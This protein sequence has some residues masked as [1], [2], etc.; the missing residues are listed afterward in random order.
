MLTVCTWLWGEK[1]S[2]DYVAKLYNGLRRHLTQP[3]QFR[4]FTDRG[5]DADVRLIPR[6]DRHLLDIKGCFARLRV[7]DPVFQRLE[8]L[9]DRIVCIDLDTVITGPLDPLFNRPEPFVILRGANA[10][11][12]N[13]FNG[14]LWMFRAGTHHDIW[15]DFELTSACDALRVAGKVYDFPDDQGWFWHKVPGAAGWKAGAASGVY[16]FQKPGWPKGEALP[17]GA[18]LVAFFGKRDPSQF[19]H[20]DWV[21]KEWLG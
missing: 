15:S 7:F 18:R 6:Q 2:G 21:K 19:V 1:Y 16:G 20:L 13:P 14:S 5:L 4:C 3:F 8:N 10:A 17:D 12:P 9:H 11:N